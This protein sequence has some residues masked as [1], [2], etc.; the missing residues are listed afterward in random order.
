L[1][2]SPASHGPGISGPSAFSASLA[3]PLLII[4]GP[5]GSGKT[6]IAIEVAK[7]VDG[8]IVGCDAL[9]VYRRFDIATA[10]PSDAQRAEVPHHLV[11]EVEPGELFTLARYVRRAET[12]IAEIVDRK[13]QPI[14][15]GGTG[16]YLRGLLRGIVD[17]PSRDEALRERLYGLRER[18]GAERLYRLLRCWDPES[19]GRLHAA[20]GQRTIR[21][22]EL[23]LSEGPSWSRR[24]EQQG[25]W[26]AG[27][28]RFPNAKFALQFDSQRLARRLEE[29][30]D[31]FFAAGLLQEVE[32]IL[33][34][35]IPESASGF[36]A[37]GYREILQCRQAGQDPRSAL[38]TIQRNTRRYAKRQRT[39]FRSEPGVIWLDAERP[40]EV[41]AGEIVTHWTANP[42]PP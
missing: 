24:L 23:L 35:G 34:D 37:I 5:T 27:A 3:S 30:V 41:V 20:D 8:E 36:K 21:A 19:A 6:E 42:H 32:A 11:D 39:W 38:P 29:R 15:V 2:R 9:Q 1:C 26:A 25:T 40:A 16:M 17:A 7:A 4:C 13:R 10:K 18:Y 14:I 33:A 28:E 22:L 12:V 31:G